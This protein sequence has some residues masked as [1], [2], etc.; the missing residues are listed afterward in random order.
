MEPF[1]YQALSQR[2]VFGSGTLARVGDEVRALKHA[3]AFVLSTPQQKDSAVALSAQLGALSAGVFAEAAMHTPVEVTERAVKAARDAA[4]DVLV[5]LGGG[6]TTGLGKAIALRTD[7]P[8]IVIPTTY[9]G[10]E[11][12]PILGRDRE[13]QEDHAAQREGSARGHPL[14]RRSDDDAAAGDVGDV[15]DER[16]RARGRGAL[17]ARTATR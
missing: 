5:S 13:R 3:R 9:A 4:A 2:V 12:T 10:S 6:S 16:H 7:L 14:R 17:C 1:V 8:Q 11:A 15:G